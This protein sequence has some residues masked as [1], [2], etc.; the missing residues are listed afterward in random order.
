MSYATPQDLED[1]FGREELIYRTDKAPVRL[2]IPDATII[3]RALADATAAIDGHLAVRYSLPLDAADPRLVKIAC[4]LA[5]YFYWGSDTEADQAV[6]MNYRDA[7]SAL[8]D[9]ATGQVVLQS[10]G[11]TAPPGAGGI[12]FSAGPRL[13]SHAGLEDFL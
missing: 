3:G 13:F 10:A 11:A 2:G 5:R 7:L 12:A 1:R 4:D 6:L 9:F 8:R